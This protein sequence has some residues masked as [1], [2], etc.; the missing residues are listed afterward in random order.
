[1]AGVLLQSAIGE[2]EV[3]IGTSGLYAIRMMSYEGNEVP[4]FLDRTMEKVRCLR[5]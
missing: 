2:H 3:T 4:L 5:S 1:M